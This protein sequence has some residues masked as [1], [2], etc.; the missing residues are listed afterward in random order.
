M[1]LDRLKHQGLRTLANTLPEQRAVPTGGILAKMMGTNRGQYTTQRM[2]ASNQRM[3]SELSRKRYKENLS[4]M[5]RDARYA[6]P[7]SIGNLALQGVQAQRQYGLGQLQA[8][9][10]KEY[11]ATQEQN[12]QE[13][14]QKIDELI[15]K[16]EQH[17]E[18]I[19]KL[20]EERGGY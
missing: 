7:L 5:K 16:I 19:D 9:Q 10:N 20:Y 4:N 2:G 15:N 12:Q 8:Q 3:L 13:Y 6:L 14:M 1:L 18:V 11:L 17:P